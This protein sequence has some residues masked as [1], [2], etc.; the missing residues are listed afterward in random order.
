MNESGTK[1]NIKD[2]FKYA[3][4]KW[5]MVLFITVFITVVFAIFG[6]VK[7]KNKLEYEI[8]YCI[9][10]YATAIVNYEE[11][12]QNYNA[13]ISNLEK[14]RTIKKN[15]YDK[16]LE[17]SE[18]SYMMNLDENNIVS[19]NKVY[20]LNCHVNEKD[21]VSNQQSAYLVLRLL[22]DDFRRYIEWDKLESNLGIS[23]YMIDQLINI[24]TNY[25]EFSITINVKWK[26][27]E[28]AELI[29]NSIISAF[30]NNKDKMSEL[31]GYSVS[32]LD[33]EFVEGEDQEIVNSQYSVSNLVDNYTDNYESDTEKLEKSIEPSAPRIEDY[34]IFGVFKSSIKYILVGIIFGIILY[35]YAFR[36]AWNIAVNFLCDKRNYRM[37]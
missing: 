1:I 10:N 37:Q 7:T 6:F 8:S 35:H 27:K 12:L 24:K 20:V 13:K 36:N 32:E 34:S 17:Y 14:A 21:N 9:F 31:N 33:V 25:S 5:K 18:N 15:L 4:T 16:V 26:D 28:G 19:C 29:M 2:F 30:T 3:Y 22:N 23:R 11:I